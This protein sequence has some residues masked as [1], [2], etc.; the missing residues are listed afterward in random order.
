MPRGMV[1]RGLSQ[2]LILFDVQSYPANVLKDTEM[3]TPARPNINERP[4]QLDT[5]QAGFSHC[6]GQ[7]DENTVPRGYKELSVGRK[8]Q[9]LD[10]TVMKVVRED[11]S[12]S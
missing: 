4:S 7:S 8:L 9:K 5:D 2:K 1:H 12:D 11:L 6:Q 3:L 10:E